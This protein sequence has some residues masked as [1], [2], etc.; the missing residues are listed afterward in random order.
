MK[1]GEARRELSDRRVKE[2]Q[3]DLRQQIREYDQV[4]AEAVEFVSNRV[5]M[6]E[7]HMEEIWKIFGDRVRSI[8]PLFET[9]VKGSKMLNRVAQ[10]LFLP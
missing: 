7:E 8:I 2:Y 6:Q 9:E 1:G 5:R 3:Q 4:G 10:H